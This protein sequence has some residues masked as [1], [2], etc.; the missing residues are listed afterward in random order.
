MNPLGA[1]WLSL[2][3]WA[4]SEPKILTRFSHFPNLQV[5]LFVAFLLTVTLAGNTVTMV[6]IGG[7]RGLRTPTLFLSALSFPGLCYTFSITPKMLS[8]AA[9]GARAIS[10][11]GCA[12]QTSFSSTAGFTRSFLL[13]VTGY[14]WP[15][16]VCHPGCYNT[17]VTS[18]GCLQLVV[19]SWL[20]GGLLGLLVTCA[21]F[22][23]PFQ[24]HQID[25]FFCHVLP[26]LQLACAAGG[27]VATMVNALCVMWKTE[28]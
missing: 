4:L 10:L 8:G 27:M 28:S 13:M 21:V 19:A 23:L 6:V 24:S 3:I 12:A 5:A 7:D 9:L 20:G 1:V 17:P 18:L 11:L 2:W 16:A 15:V 22:Q 14:D 25:Q 26:L